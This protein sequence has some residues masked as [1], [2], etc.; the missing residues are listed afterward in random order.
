M[1]LAWRTSVQPS[2]PSSTR[3]GFWQRPRGSV[4]GLG[5]MNLRHM[6]APGVV[7][8]S[9]PSTPPYPLPPPPLSS[10][11]PSEI[12]QQSLQVGSPHSFLVWSVLVLER[13]GEKRG[14]GRL[15][16]LC[17]G[18]RG[19]GGGK[20]VRT[21]LLGCTELGCQ[22]EKSVGSEH[23]IACWRPFGVFHSNNSRAQSW[24]FS[25]GI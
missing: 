5:E 1:P 12:S 11:T 17:R 14:F 10:P 20:T 7:Q 16:K 24:A 9:L 22:A 13:R 3:P 4:E 19:P 21:K 18:P 8:R 15:T 2:R 25:F 23:R 6:A